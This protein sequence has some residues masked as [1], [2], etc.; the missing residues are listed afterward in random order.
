MD[1]RITIADYCRA[2]TPRW[3]AENT[4]TATPNP[5]PRQAVRWWMDHLDEN[6]SL[7]GNGHRKNI[8]S[9]DLTELGVGVVRG[10]ANPDY[11]G[12]GGTFVQDFGSCLH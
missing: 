11:P 4:Y 10:S 2:P 8:L 1:S 3:I 7:A 6:G 5:T 9:R 12:P